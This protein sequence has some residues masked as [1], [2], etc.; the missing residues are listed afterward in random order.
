M[1]PK[2]V[3]MPEMVEAIMAK[4]DRQ[5]LQ[6][7]EP[8]LVRGKVRAAMQQLGFS[9]AS[10][11]VTTA[12]TKIIER[13]GIVVAKRPKPSVQKKSPKRVPSISDDEVLSIRQQA[14]L[15]GPLF[16]RLSVPSLMSKSVSSV[17]SADFREFCRLSLLEN[18]V[19]TSPQTLDELIRWLDDHAYILLSDDGD[20]VEVIGIP[21]APPVPAPAPHSGSE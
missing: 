21:V 15:L 10:M 3:L 12:M 20:F 9:L 16:R 14:A 11:L 17:P 7:K 19:N 2:Q 1:W 4:L 13:W 18:G 6:G 8:A 5:E